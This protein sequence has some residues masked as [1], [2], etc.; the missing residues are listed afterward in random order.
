MTWEVS[1]QHAFRQ[2]FDRKSLLHLFVCG[3]R[4]GATPS[5]QVSQG[6]W[7]LIP[8]ASRLRQQDGLPITK[9]G[10]DGIQ[11]KDVYNTSGIILSS[12]IPA[13][14]ERESI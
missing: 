10:S 14:W 5:R 12:V 6:L 3:E 2:S 7:L 4:P 1:V 13:D 8:H 11:Q 9:V